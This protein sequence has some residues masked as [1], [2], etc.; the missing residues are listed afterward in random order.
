MPLFLL[1]LLGFSS[2][3]P[4]ALTASTL[5]LWLA[6][7]GVSKASIGLFAAVATPYAL[8]F[9]WAPLVDHLRLPGFTH[10]LGQRRGWLLPVQS[11]LMIAIAALG[12]A[13]PQEHAGTTA[14]LALIVAFFS[15]T[16]DMVIDAMR[17]ESFAQEK[18]GTA[19]ATLVMGYR[20][21]MIASSAGA[22]FLAAEY[23]WQTAYF[24]MAALIGIGM[25]AALAM[26]ESAHRLK[27]L[28]IRRAFMQYAVIAP[29]AEFRTRQS[30]K[31]I[32]L[33]VVL[34]KFGDAFL[35]IMTNPFLLEI[36]F[37]KTQIATIVKLYG[38]VATITGGFLG[39]WIVNKC[40][41]MRALWVCGFGHALTNLMFLWQAQMGANETVLAATISLENISGG[42]STA[43]FVAYL[44]SLCNRQF[45]ATQYALLSSLSAFG[46][47]WLS[48]PAGFFAQALGWQWF[49]VLATLLAFPGLVI[50]WFIQRSTPRHP[51]RA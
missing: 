22:V 8:K 16:Q 27:P 6:E 32:L 42:M 51:A 35:G 25:V 10:M 21:G 19:S 45:T 36:G 5:T 13:N 2:G 20:I 12:L 49:F 26:P 43:A 28:Q 46:R 4:L 3:L 41:L 23:G 40:G 14:V 38:L 39:G 9:L 30:W 48:T 17:V 44:S 31:L 15:A 37:S 1:S 24:C 33:F 18:Q 34:Y 7:E 29:F 11:L 50:L 47:S